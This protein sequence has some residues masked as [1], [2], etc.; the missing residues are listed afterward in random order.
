MRFES[1]T[2]SGYLGQTNE[3]PL[4]LSLSKDPTAG[5][6]GL[7]KAAGYYFLPNSRAKNPGLLTAW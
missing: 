1:L 4:I 2:M 5:T 7:E 3:C 6:P